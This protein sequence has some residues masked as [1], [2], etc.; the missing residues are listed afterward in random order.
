MVVVFSLAAAAAGAS[1]MLTL[2]GW[3]IMVE[4]DNNSTA[5]VRGIYPSMTFV[6][7]LHDKSLWAVV[8][9]LVVWVVVT[10]VVVE[11]SDVV[12]AVLVVILSFWL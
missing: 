9:V 4:D 1:G 10:V 6:T 12:A 5:P 8:L 3:S 11:S 2:V 7:C